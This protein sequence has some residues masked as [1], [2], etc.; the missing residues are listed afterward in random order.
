V[1]G[2]YSTVRQG[3]ASVIARGFLDVRNDAAHDALDSTLPVPVSLPTIARRVTLQGA[4]FSG[5]D[6]DGG[7]GVIVWY[8]TL[9][10]TV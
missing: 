6:I 4:D 7:D 10:Q 1:N 9:Y 3:G 8:Q 2:P 5:A